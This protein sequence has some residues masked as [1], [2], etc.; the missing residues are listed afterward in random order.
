LRAG[1]R[2][3]LAGHRAA[4]AHRRAARARAHHQKPDQRVLRGRGR[5]DVR[6]RRALAASPPSGTTS[7]PCANSVRNQTFQR[8]RRDMNI[9]RSGLKA[10]KYLQDLDRDDVLETLGL[11]ERR[12]GIATT[13]GTIVIFELGCMVWSGIGL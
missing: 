4:V 13:L 5:A 11:H 1:R 6:E 7:P 8:R 3:L 12:S 9:K 2:A 10:L